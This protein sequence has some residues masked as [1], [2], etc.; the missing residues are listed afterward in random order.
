MKKLIA[1]CICL[2]TLS[3]VAFAQQTI[4]PAK[5]GVN[6]GKSVEKKNAI[7]IQKLESA[8][9]GKSDYTGQI[10]GQVVEVCKS[11]G[12][13]MAI[14]RD[15]AEPIMVRFK[16]YGYFVPQDLVGKTVVIEGKAKTKEPKGDI[17]FIADGVLVVK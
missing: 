5:A 4:Q 16:D 8:L 1:V 7:S 13:Y 6:Y 15:G 14:K 10:E 2:F 9:Q 12:C 11:K 17:T 3:T